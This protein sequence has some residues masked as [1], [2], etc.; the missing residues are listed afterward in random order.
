MISRLSELLRTTLSSGGQQEVPLREEI[1]ILQKYVDI[2]LIRFQNRLRVE[3]DIE[4][5]VLDAAV[6]AMILQPLV[7]NSIRHGIA[8]RSAAGWIGVSA[9]REGEQLLIEVSDDGPGATEPIDQ[10][11][12]KGV[13]LTNTRD[14]LREL[15]GTHQ[16]FEIRSRESSDADDTG[17][18]LR[19]H[20]PYREIQSSSGLGSGRSRGS[21]RRSSG[22]HL[23]TPSKAAAVS[24]EVDESKI[25]RTDGALTV[26]ES[27][28]DRDH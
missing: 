2:E 4:P 22:I 28:E 5:T 14:R 23:P 9:W 3:M 12:G 16:S 8:R 27:P 11:L 25:S 18:T 20:I 19:I 21:R 10:L 17:L 26:D 15:H 13:G 1:G 7:E 6:P 24:T